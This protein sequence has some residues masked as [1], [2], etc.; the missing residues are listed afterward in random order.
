MFDSIYFLSS[1]H[2]IRYFLSINKP[3]D[4]NL[5]VV[6]SNAEEALKIFL[7]DIIPEPKIMVLPNLKNNVGAIYVNPFYRFY[8]TAL[9]LT[10]RFW[11][12]RSFKNIS[13]TTK[14][15]YFNNVNL[16][17]LVVLKYLSKKGVEV[18]F[19]DAVDEEHFLVSSDLA[20][21]SWKK[22][23]DLALFGLASGVQ[24]SWKQHFAKKK[25]KI[26]KGNPNFPSSLIKTDSWESIAKK[27][28]WTF[29][30]NP[31]NAVLLVDA[32]FQSI[33][34]LDFEKSEENIIK[35]FSRI[36]D[37]GTEIH[38]KAHYGTTFQ[39][40]FVGTPLEDKVKLLNPFVPSELYLIHY[41]ISYFFSSYSGSCP[42]DGK[43]FS[44]IKLLVFNIK[45]RHDFLWN[46]LDYVWGQ[47]REKIEF[48]ELEDLGA[49]TI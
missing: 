4:N 43:K 6:N 40:S 32:P 31:K 29:D 27:Y 25:L 24:L 39:H 45:E 36:I 34:G 17:Y 49:K 23:L 9:L 21:I 19:I 7:R 26:L 48:V 33:K 13:S 38:V 15:Y 3:D 18:T 37:N 30:E 35:F 42:C 47:E 8:F 12:S 41:P 14:A 46:T 1:Y 10:F 11:H 5:I 44:L 16:N 22:R 2:G 20:A 28:Q